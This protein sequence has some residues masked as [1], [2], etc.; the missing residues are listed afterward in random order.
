MCPWN[1]TRLKSE[2]PEFYSP[3]I[4]WELHKVIY[5]NPKPTDMEKVTDRAE[6]FGKDG[7]FECKDILLKCPSKYKDDPNATK[8]AIDEKAG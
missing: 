2:F 1:T 3:L 4:R 6:R 7:Q 5:H 8:Q